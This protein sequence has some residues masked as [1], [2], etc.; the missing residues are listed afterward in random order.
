MHVSHLSVYRC[1][2][3]FV[4]ITWL[5]AQYIDHESLQVG[6]EARKSYIYIYIYIIYSYYSGRAGQFI[7]IECMFLIKISL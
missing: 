5:I 3:V 6:T 7:V 4:E 2:P 1:K